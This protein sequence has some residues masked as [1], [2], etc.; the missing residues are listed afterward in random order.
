MTRKDLRRNQVKPIKHGLDYVRGPSWAPR[1]YTL[2]GA[3]RYADQCAAR[4]APA[5]FWSGL[6]S[7]QGDYW[8]VNVAGQGETR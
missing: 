7:D 1:Q 5:G 8:R 3:Q 6:V 2:R 4:K